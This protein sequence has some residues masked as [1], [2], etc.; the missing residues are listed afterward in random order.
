MG[1][2]LA[3]RPREG[4]GGL[5]CQG[6]PRGPQFLFFLPGLSTGHRQTHRLLPRARSTQPHT[7]LR[8]FGIGTPKLSQ[9]CLPDPTATDLSP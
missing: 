4:K 6:L 9:T 7:M 8:A 1:A 3:A 2:P 5:F